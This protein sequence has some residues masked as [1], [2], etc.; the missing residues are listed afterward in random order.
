MPERQP[1]P[2][3]VRCPWQVERHERPFVHWTIGGLLTAAEAADAYQAVADCWKEQGLWHHYDNA[4]EKKSASTA[5][6]AAPGLA[7]LFRWWLQPAFVRELQRQLGVSI[8]HLQADDTLHGGGVHVA[9]PGGHLGQHVD[10]ALHPRLNPPRERRL[11]LLV[12]LVPE[13]RPEWGG[14]TVLH[15]EQGEARWQELVYPAPGAA[16]AWEPSDLSYHGMQRVA[17]GCPVLRASAAVYYVAPARKSAVRR[18]AL[19]T[20]PRGG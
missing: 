3:V 12:Y 9:G 8:V 17:D 11:N 15:G 16:L 14:A 5:A 10:Y 13:W 2:P 18:R 7:S 4:C 20:P 6:A 19:F 1:I